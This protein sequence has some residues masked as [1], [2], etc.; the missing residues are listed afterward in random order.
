MT[1]STAVS[2]LSN[3]AKALG[4]GAGITG[5]L[6][7]GVAAHFAL[8]SPENE[9]KLDA[10]GISTFSDR[11]ARATFGPMTMFAAAAIGAGIGKRS[12]SAALTT[13]SLG[14]A[15]MMASPAAT[16]LTNAESPDADKNL[17]SM[18]VL[19]AVAAGGF[20]VGAID[21]VPL[22]VAKVSGLVAVGLAIGTFLPETAKYVSN[23]PG[24]LVRGVQ[25]RNGE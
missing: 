7:L 23:M 8:P 2:T 1:T 20:A 19:G 16:G 5:G 24:D 22:N 11:E 13:A 6:G 12:E 9:R 25:H 4:L 14:A 3:G 18:G 17:R 15:A 10:K 21:E